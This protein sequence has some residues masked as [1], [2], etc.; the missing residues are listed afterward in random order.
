MEGKRVIKKILEKKCRSGGRRKS[1]LERYM[2]GGKDSFGGGGAREG[3][4]SRRE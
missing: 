4:K 2:D 3:V 1:R